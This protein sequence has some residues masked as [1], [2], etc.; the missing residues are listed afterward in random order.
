MIMSNFRFSLRHVGRQKLNTIL[1][2][3]GLTLGMS[4]CLLI[5]LFLR[6]ELSFD[7]YHHHADRIYRVNSVWTEGGTKKFNL[8]ATPIPLAE[9]LRNEIPGLEKVALTRPQFETVIE[10][11]PQKLFKQEHVLIVEPEFLDIFNIEVLQGDAHKALR[12]PYQALLTETIAKKFFGNENPVGKSFKYRNKFI[13]T[14]AGIIRDIPSNTSLPASILLSYVANNE[15]L[16]NGDT[17]YFGGLDWTKLAAI[18]Y[19]VLAENYDPKNLQARLKRIA[20]KN[21]N[22]APTVDKM[23]RGDFEIQ[24][25]PDIHFDTK[26]FGG[27]PWVATVNR[28]WL[29]FFAGIGLVVLAL[30]CINF[31][32]LST[33]QALTRA[34]EV[35]IRKSVGARRSQLISQFLLEACILTVASGVLSL[36]ITQLSLHPI[37]NLLGKGITFHPLQSPGLMAVLLLGIALTTLL[38]GLYP[39]WAMARFN[40]VLTLKS[41]SSGSGLHGSSWLRKGLV[42]MQFAISASLLMVVLVISK[43]V[44]FMQSK[45]LGFDKHNIISVAIGDHGKAKTLEQE[46][47][48]IRGVKD[49]SLNRSSPISTDHWW[50]TMSK[51]ETSDRQS[52]CAIYGDD[53]FYTLFGLRLLSGR[54]PASSEY[55]SN[56]PIGN[57]VVN[58]KLLQAFDLGSPQEAIGKHFWWGSDTEIIGVV[59]DFNAEPLQ[60]AVPPTL[61]AQDPKVYSQITIKIEPGGDISPTL[62]AI[63]ASWKKTFPD[64]V[65]EFRFL[66]DQID[67]Y[68]K[69]ETKFNTLFKIFAVLAIFISCLGLWG[70]VTFA[71]QQRTKEIGIRKV[72]GAS[73]RIVVMLLSKDFLLLVLIAFAVSSPLT[74]YF[75][76]ELLQNFAFRVDIGW[77]VFVITGVALIIVTLFTVSFRTMKAA[78]ANPVESLRSE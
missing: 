4:V 15:F 58:E 34:K 5:G 30:A 10:I 19:V 57:V 49:V 65:Y 16:D 1:H 69:M 12:T 8:Y 37:N 23:V 11:N 17:W 73:V 60:F 67:S 44:N 33:A 20:D 77:E 27:G 70:L 54:I 61:I 18:T 41:G 51:T 43:Q 52:V 66:D 76:K 47:R 68:Y 50:N 6:Y 74:Y 40:P 78:L 39:A 24:A 3:V 48:Q 13:I 9:A 29:W 71:S 55:M 38:A 56:Q 2:V 7:A 64:G 59:A 53:N 32:N 14:V 42:V 31:L 75:M 62:S 46:L 45:D 63:E 35:G 28:T 22:S 25:L 72:L 21:I 36:L 26:Y